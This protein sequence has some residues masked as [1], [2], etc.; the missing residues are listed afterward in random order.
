MRAAAHNTVPHDATRPS[1]K[2]GAQ[3][4]KEPLTHTASTFHPTAHTTALMSN[5]SGLSTLM[6]TPTHDK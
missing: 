5:N 4:V 2:A 3:A 6:H 1:P